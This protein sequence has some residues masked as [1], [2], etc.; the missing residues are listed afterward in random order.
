MTPVMPLPWQLPRRQSLSLKKQIYPFA[1]LLSGAEVLLRTDMVLVL[2]QL[3]SL[4]YWEW[5]VLGY[6]KNC[7][8]QF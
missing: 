8:F 6:E 7:K 4:D 1:T 3:S 2:S 5:M